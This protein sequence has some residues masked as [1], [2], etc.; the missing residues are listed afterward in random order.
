MSPSNELAREIIIPAS[1]GGVA[2][3]F[4]HAMNVAFGVETVLF[5]VQFTVP[6]EPFRETACPLSEAPHVAPVA[7]S[8]PMPPFSP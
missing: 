3:G 1:D 5:C 7:D 2:S 8:E 6:V 4:T